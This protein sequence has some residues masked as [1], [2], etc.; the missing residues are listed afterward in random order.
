MSR[1]LL[2]FAPPRTALVRFGVAGGLLAAL[3]AVAPARADSVPA[4]DHV[5][6]VIMENKS[7][8]EVRTA[9]YTAGLIAQS[10]SF[11]QSHAVTHPSQPNYL[12]L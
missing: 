5:V 6:V 2:R 9:P 3:L 1:P 8:D 4:F 7:Y 11:S 12:A 10:T